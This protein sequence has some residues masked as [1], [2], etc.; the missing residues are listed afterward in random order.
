[1]VS[2]EV[3]HNEVGQKDIRR[4][5]DQMSGLNGNSS[6]VSRTLGASSSTRPALKSYGVDTMFGGAGINH[7]S[8]SRTTSFP[9]ATAE[10]RRRS[11]HVPAS[12]YQ[13]S[14]LP[15]METLPLSSQGWTSGVVTQLRLVSPAMR[16]M[17]YHPGTKAL[18]SQP[19]PPPHKTDSCNE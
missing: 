16:R 12:E 14:G 17:Q 13:T 19:L 3:E 18:V 4:H 2:T 6:R 8:S 5:Y 1:M 10:N 7:T 9:A 11:V 15:R